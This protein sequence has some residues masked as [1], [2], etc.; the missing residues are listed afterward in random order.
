MSCSAKK[1]TDVCTHTK[2]TT[3]TKSNALPPY[4]DLNTALPPYSCSSCPARKLDNMM[5]AGY[6][7]QIPRKNYL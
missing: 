1:D 4:T 6:P 2:S 7:V 5:K 3:E